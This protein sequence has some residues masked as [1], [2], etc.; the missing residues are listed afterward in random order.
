METQKRFPQRLG[1][2]AQDARFPHSH[3]RSSFLNKEKTKN[4][5]VMGIV[6]GHKHSG[7][8]RIVVANR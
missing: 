7:P 4:E 3:S 2:L 6:T 1:N 8:A 5:E